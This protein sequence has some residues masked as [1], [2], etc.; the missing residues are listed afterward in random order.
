MRV[1]MLHPHDPRYDP[2]TIRILALARGLI[3]RGHKATVAYLPKKKIHE[4]D[5]LLRRDYAEQA[6]VVALGSRHGDLYRNYRTLRSLADECDIVHIQKCFASVA[7]PGVWAAYHS[8]KPVHLDWDDNES[9]LA[10]LTAP[11]VIWAHLIKVW[12]RRLPRLVDSLSVSSQG[13]HDLASACGVRADRICKI[14]VGADLE[15]FSPAHADPGWREELDLNPDSVLAVYCGQLEGA[16]YADLAFEAFRCAR[17]R[18]ESIHLA[19]IGGGRGLPGLRDK[20][21][22]AGG[23][24]VTLTGYV[25]AEDVPRYLASADIALACFE[26]NAATRCKSPLKIAEYLASGLAIVGSA[27][28]D[29]PEM[30]GD[31]GIVV[32]PGDAE[33][34]ADGI[35]AF[36]NDPE[37][38]NEY[39]QRARRRAE[40]VYHWQRSADILADAYTRLLS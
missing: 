15:T 8:G 32:P 23:G 1:L 6:P 3:A 36:V 37:L 29:V 14:P 5:R 33:A 24:D 21:A 12:E 40:T 11:D 13:V 30:I 17:E 4:H 19:V 28:G 34:L 20:V 22:D 35:M 26:D 38:R 2:W 25:P 39:R 31:A 9:A 7:C 16:A 27:V 10:D 18:T